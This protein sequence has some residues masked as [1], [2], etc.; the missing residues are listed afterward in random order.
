MKES[1][2]KASERKTHVG[3]CAEQFC[4]GRQEGTKEVEEVWTSPPGR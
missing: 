3:E 1:V 2:Y 4:N